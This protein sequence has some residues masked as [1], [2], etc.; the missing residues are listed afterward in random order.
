[1]ILLLLLLFYSE[2]TRNLVPHESPRNQKKDNYQTPGIIFRVSR[3][4]VF[5]VY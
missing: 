1:M 2:V 3:K 4:T 5:V